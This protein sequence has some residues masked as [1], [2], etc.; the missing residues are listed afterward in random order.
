MA[1]AIV[2]A[3]PSRAD[4]RFISYVNRFFCSSALDLTPTLYEQLLGSFKE[5]GGSWYRL[6]RGSVDDVVLIK[7]LVKAQ[8]KRQRDD[9]EGA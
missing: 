1:K 2:Q 5:E 7:R 3:D 8:A 9:K 6:F 4:H